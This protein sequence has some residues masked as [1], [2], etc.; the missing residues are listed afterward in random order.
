MDKLFSLLV[1]MLIL[2][3]CDRQEQFAFERAEYSDLQKTEDFE[4][5]FKLLDEHR[6]Y[7]QFSSAESIYAIGPSFKKIDRTNNILV[8]DADGILYSVDGSSA[9]VNF[10]NVKGAFFNEEE[11]CLLYEVRGG[12][13]LLSY[14]IHGRTKSQINLNYRFKDLA[15]KIDPRVISGDKIIVMINYGFG[16]ES[17]KQINVFGSSGNHLWAGDTYLPV[18]VD[19]GE[20][21]AIFEEG[22]MLLD[23]FKVSKHLPADFKFER[24]SSFDYATFDFLQRL[25]VGKNG[26]MLIRSVSDDGSLSESPRSLLVNCIQQGEEIKFDYLLSK[27]DVGV[28]LSKLQVFNFDVSGGR[29]FLASEKSEVEFVLA[30]GSWTRREAHTTNRYYSTLQYSPLIDSRNK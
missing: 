24:H 15:Y 8:F 17:H 14:D 22:V 12:L 28:S 23:G 13:R 5:P 6:K 25:L 30:D 7:H 3:A 9:A 19:G 2:M 21:A 4:F 10:E 1:L 29:F 20:M 11:F 26:F 27:S 18:Y 16:V